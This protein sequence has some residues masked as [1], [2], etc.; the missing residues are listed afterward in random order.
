[1]PGRSC[2]VTIQDIDGVS[3][4]VKIARRHSLR[5]HGSRTGGRQWDRSRP[6]IVKVSVANVPLRNEGKLWDLTEWLDRT[7][8]SPREVSNRK[9]IRA[10]L[11]RCETPELHPQIRLRL[12]FHDSAGYRASTWH[13]IQR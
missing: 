8:G 3:H 12:S 9:R 11:G 6:D 2:R 4:T 13:R 7:G 1:M 5:S 10:I